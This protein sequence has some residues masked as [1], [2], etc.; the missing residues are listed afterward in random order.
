MTT[1]PCGRWARTSNINK[2]PGE[3]MT[4][5]VLAAI[6]RQTNSKALWSLLV[7]YYHDHGIDKVS[8]HHISVDPAARQS[9]TINTEGFSQAWV[10][11][12]IERKLFL[13]DPITELAHSATR[14]FLWSEI[15]ELMRLSP[16]Q[17]AYL[18]QMEQAGVGNGLAFQV[19]G[20]GLRNGYVGLGFAE[21]TPV[22]AHAQM[23][24]LQLIA[25]AGHMKYCALNPARLLAGHL[26]RRERQILHW[27]ARG[28]S[29][30]IIADI[31]DLSPHTVDTLVRRIFD[32][33]GVTDRTTAAIQGVGSG[34]IRP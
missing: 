30:A 2:H 11:Q 3:R 15:G 17:K 20:P 31:L 14:P 13:V 18:D 5:S 9:V 7:A 33:L 26:S 28:K 6:D 16:E 10:C 32:K 8:Y 29:N 34:L 27:I 24:E 1:Y 22:P 4:E 19:F 23:I 12:Y 25:Q 21:A